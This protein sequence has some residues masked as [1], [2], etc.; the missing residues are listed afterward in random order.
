MILTRDPRFIINL[1]LHVL[2]LYYFFKPNRNYFIEL[3]VFAI[4]LL[5]TFLII[6][7]PL[8]VSYFPKLR[9]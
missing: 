3:V 9:K 2:F 6:V 4:M 7:P 5:F 1:T 8:G